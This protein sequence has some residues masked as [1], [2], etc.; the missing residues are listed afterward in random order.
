[1]SLRKYADGTRLI[2][3][4]MFFLAAGAMSLNGLR[5]VA[6]IDPDLADGVSG[7]FFGLAIGCLV[8]GFRA[9][10]RRRPAAGSPPDA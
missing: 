7:L 8:L 1:M 4:G 3:V 6:P 10:Y 5:R 9:R 2:V